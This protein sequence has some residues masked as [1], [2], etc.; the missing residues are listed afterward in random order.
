MTPPSARI[1]IGKVKQRAAL[2]QPLDAGASRVCVRSGNAEAAEA[3]AQS[4]KHFAP[5][6]SARRL[7]MEGRL[8]PKLQ[9]RAQTPH[10]HPDKVRHENQNAPTHPTHPA[11][12]AR[13]VP[14]RAQMLRAENFDP[15]AKLRLIRRQRPS[16]IQGPL[17]QCP[18]VR[19]QQAPARGRSH[20]RKRQLQ[21]SPRRAPPPANQRQRQLPQAPA[22]KPPRP[23]GQTPRHSQQ[24][25]SNSSTASASSSSSGGGD[26]RN[27]A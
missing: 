8:P 16:Q 12:P 9:R 27:S 17:A 2:T 6:L 1:H 10:I 5:K 26:G 14:C 24:N 18:K 11:H 3:S 22:Q 7:V 25:Q 19:Q 4:V 21:I 23:P 20:L 13:P 15:G